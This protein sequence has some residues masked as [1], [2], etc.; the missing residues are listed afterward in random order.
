MGDRVQLQQ[1]IFNLI[2]NAIQA[3]GG[4]TDGSRE[5][6]LISEKAC[7]SQRGSKTE[8]RSNNKGHA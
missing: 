5:L 3:M 6:E 8:K 1:V 4:V 2:L 7:P